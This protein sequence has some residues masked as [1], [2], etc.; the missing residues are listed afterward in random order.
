MTSTYWDERREREAKE[1]EDFI[2]CDK[3][4]CSK[5][6]RFVTSLNKQNLCPECAGEED[7]I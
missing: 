4:V 3:L 6:D 5:C 2:D 1:R 7:D